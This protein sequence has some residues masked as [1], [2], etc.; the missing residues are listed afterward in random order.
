VRLR[1]LSGT[2]GTR[3]AALALAALL[4]AGSIAAA[5]SLAATW[6]WAD[7]ASMPAPV[8]RVPGAPGAAGLPPGSA[9]PRGRAPTIGTAAAGG[10][11]ATGEG[12]ADEGFTIEKLL[13][14]V[15]GA[16]T[17][18]LALM[19]VT[20][21]NPLTGALALV[22]SFFCLSALYVMLG[23]HFIAAVQII[24]YAG[25]IMVLFVFVIMLLN[26]SD[27][28]LGAAKHR[29]IKGLA[30]ATL[31]VLGWLTWRNLSALPPA[32]LGAPVAVAADFGTV[33]GVG[34]TFFGDWLFPFELAGVLLLVAVVG[35]VAIS[36]RAVR[37][38]AGSA[39]GAPAPAPAPA[40][41]PAAGGH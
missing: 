21:R 6:A 12:A 38:A 13:F 25:A 14:L 5:V 11:T 20:L 18:L 40:A 16:T 29:F 33:K 8:P 36:R 1:G 39:A 32:P 34:R 17:A 9:G 35:A 3:A 30:L 37:N 41:P 23:A 2:R 15:F 31:A 24:I 26:L 4:A 7:T 27:R 10:G 19:V 22:G 28:E